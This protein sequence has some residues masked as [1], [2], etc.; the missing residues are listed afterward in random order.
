[1][2]TAVKIFATVWFVSLSAVACW[3]MWFL[4]GVPG[5]GGP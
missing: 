4:P 1:M 3:L 2:E 5:V